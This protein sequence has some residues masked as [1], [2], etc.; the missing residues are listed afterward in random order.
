VLPNKNKALKKKKKPAV[1]KECKYSTLPDRI[2]EKAGGRR[3]GR[4]FNSVFVWL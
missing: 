1:P 2:Q 4:A 3:T